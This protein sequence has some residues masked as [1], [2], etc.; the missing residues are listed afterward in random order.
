[1]AFI[2]YSSGSFAHGGTVEELCLPFLAY[3][4]FIGVRSILD[5]SEI[6]LTDMLLIGVTSSVILW[7][8]YSLLGFYIGWIIMPFYMALKK[9]ALKHFLAG[10]FMIGV[11][12]AVVSIPILFWYE[13]HGALGDLMQAYFYNNIFVYSRNAGVW[14]KIRNMISGVH[15]SLVYF[16][17]PVLLMV[18]GFIYYCR[19][20]LRIAML[21]LLSGICTGAAIFSGGQGIHYYPMVL[22]PLSLIGILALNDWL[23]RSGATIKK[24]K[25]ALIGLTLASMISMYCFSSNTYLLKYQEADFPQLRFKEIIC[26]EKNPTLLNYGFLDGGFYTACEIYP[27]FKFFCRLN[28]D[29]PEMYAAQDEYISKKIPLFIVTRDLEP[30]FPGYRCVTSASY[31]HEGRIYDYYLY[32]RE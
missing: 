22:A 8:K 27:E 30:V 3:A 2:V 19:K 26:R 29:L 31:Y 25:L 13:S 4:L 28:I 17:I 12:V 10:V 18:F 6:S 1:M 21:F 9:K 14:G 20:N 5:N 15:L 24:R 11:G 32:R 23:H 7:T 16:L